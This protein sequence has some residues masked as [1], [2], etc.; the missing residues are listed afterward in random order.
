MKEY[1]KKAEEIAKAINAS[2][3]HIYVA[4]DEEGNDVV[5]Y[6][7]DPSYIQKLAAM[8][9]VATVGPFMAGEELRQIL[10]IQEHSDS[11][12]YAASSECDKYRLGMASRCLEIVEIAAN[13]FK[14]K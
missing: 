13:E 1:Q 14:K 3:V 7:K 11:R 8:D 4:K 10:T 6:I 5:G 12:T 2:K 9:K